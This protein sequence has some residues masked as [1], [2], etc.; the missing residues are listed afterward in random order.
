MR[1]FADKMYIFV[2]RV[3][4]CSGPGRALLPRRLGTTGID[5]FVCAMLPSSGSDLLYCLRCAG[6]FNLLEQPYYPNYG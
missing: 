3:V 6:L 5:W 4:R 1:N 2:H